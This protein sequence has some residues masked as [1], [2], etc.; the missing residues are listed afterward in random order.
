MLHYLMT[1]TCL[2]QVMLHESVCESRQI[3]D[4]LLVGVVFMR[5]CS[6]IIMG[7]DESLQYNH[8][9]LV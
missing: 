1:K 8:R 9:S 7:R 5:H 4:A 2:L 6:I 3:W